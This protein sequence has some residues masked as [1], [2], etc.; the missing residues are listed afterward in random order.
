MVFALAARS[1][2]TSS[3]RPS[4]AQ[5]AGARRGYAEEASDKLRLSFVLPHKAEYNNEEVTQVNVSA[6]S[7]DLGILSS[8]VPSIE[9]LRPG[10]MEVIESNGT[11]KRFFVSGGFATIHPNNRLTINAVEGFT[12]D[13][14]SPE[15]VRQGLAEAQRHAGSSSGVEKVEAEIAVDVFTALQAALAQK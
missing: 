2:R 4:M 3:L 5:L 10:V 9:E 15:A 14:F 12:L 13:S 6:S 11:N 8:H 7:G 1:L